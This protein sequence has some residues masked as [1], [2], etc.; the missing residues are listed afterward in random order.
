MGIFISWG[1]IL[2]LLFGILKISVLDFFKFLL[3]L[4]FYILL[5]GYI[6]ARCFKNW[7]SLSVLFTLCSISGMCF[8]VGTFIISSFL[9]IP[10]IIYCVGPVLSFISLI[11]LYI[12]SKK[13]EQAKR[14]LKIDFGLLFVIS[15]FLLYSIVVRATAAASPGLTGSMSYFMDSLYIVTNSSAMTGGLF[16]ESLNFPGFLLRYHAVTNVLQACAINVTGI[17]AMNIFTVFWPFLYLTTALSALHAAITTYRQNCRWASI[18]VFTCMVSEIFTV[19]I[20]YLFDLGKISEKLYMATGNLE[21]YL[22]VLPNGIDIALPAILAIAVII[23]KYY[24]KECSSKVVLVT[25]MLV[26]ALATGAKATF[27]I[28]ICGA[29]LGSC[30]F[31]LFQKKKREKWKK[32]FG[33]FIA[34]IIGFGLI[35]FIMIYNS[36]PTAQSTTTLFNLLDE[37][38][39]L[40][41]ENTLSRMLELLGPKVTDWAANHEIIALCVIFPFSVLFLLPFFMPAFL[42]WAIKELKNFQNMSLSSMFIGGISLCGLAAYYIV[43]FDGYSQVYF[44]FASICFVQIAGFY[45]LIDNYRDLRY[46]IKAFFIIMLV[47]SIFY[48]YHDSLDRIKTS[49]RTI[50]TILAENYINEKEEIPSPSW[51]SITKYEYEGMIWL[52]ENTPKNSVIAIDRFFNAPQGNRSM[53]E[54]IDDA[55]YFYYPAYSERHM[56]LSGFAYSPRSDEMYD[57]LETQLDVLSK[58]YDPDY[59]NRKQLMKDNNISYLVVSTF[60][61]GN[62]EFQDDTLAEVFRNRDIIIYKLLK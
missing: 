31:I 42:A 23:I 3:Y 36:S 22:L 4:A 52:K 37:R 39:S 19:S 11:L 24:R 47:C 62:L 44:W 27:G 34:S 45:W 28:C 6:L 41:F 40:H 20:F 32:V 13:A 5:P 15:L 9:R 54:A 59:N 18:A 60:V 12:D 17:S 49:Y 1:C 21:A 53:L 46:I 58:I 14:T 35:Y 26:T 48:T 30:I 57:W 25:V 8:L 38:N 16:A 7:R 55:L 56:F 2:V 10:W 33:L 50:R 43:T 51:N 61:S 29:L